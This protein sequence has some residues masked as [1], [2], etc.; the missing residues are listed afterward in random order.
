MD[1]AGLVCEVRSHL[2]KLGGGRVISIESPYGFVTKVLGR[3]YRKFVVLTVIDLFL[4]H[5]RHRG[6]EEVRL[7]RGVDNENSNL[8]LHG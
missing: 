8:D 5:I 4:S 7:A 2:R 6:V 1:E 3:L